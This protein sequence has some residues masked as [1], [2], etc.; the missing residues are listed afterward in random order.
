MWSLICAP[1]S[2]AVYLNRRCNYGMGKLHDKNLRNVIAYPCPNHD[3]GF[4]NLCWLIPERN[5][6]LFLYTPPKKRKKKKKKNVENK[7]D[8]RLLNSTTI[9]MQ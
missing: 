4:T 2:T 8:H 9:L 6:T 5:R 1:T 7:P 3:A